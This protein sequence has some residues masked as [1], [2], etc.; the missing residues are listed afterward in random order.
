ME[1]KTG[2]K[3]FLIKFTR[4]LLIFN[5]NF[6]LCVC[7][8]L[9]IRLQMCYRKDLQNN[10]QYERELNMPSCRDVYFFD[11]HS[12]LERCLGYVLCWSQQCLIESYVAGSHSHQ[13]S[14]F[15]FVGLASSAVAVQ[16]T[17]I[18]V[19][20]QQ[21]PVFQW[22]IIQFLCEHGWE[23]ELEQSDHICTF[24]MRVVTLPKKC[25]D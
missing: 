17:L 19:G 24:S 7:R 10:V 3:I 9:R 20:C 2:I 16:A 4:I 21:P 5:I 23:G 15:S 25:A 13:I 8:W 6:L 12:Y 1:S 11:Y 22:S 18:E 14:C